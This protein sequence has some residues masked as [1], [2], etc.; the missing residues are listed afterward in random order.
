MA[1]QK[2]CD[3]AQNVY[4]KNILKQLHAKVSWKK[5]L[6]ELN[7]LKAMCYCHVI[8]ISMF[9]VTN[10][11]FCVYSLVLLFIYF[12]LL[13]G[14]FFFS[15]LLKIATTALHLIYL[16]MCKGFFFLVIIIQLL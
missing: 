4:I 5:V 11:C 6:F 2:V 8:H 14:S 15:F 1:T 10:M 7:A 3:T 12:L 16:F 13:W 9:T